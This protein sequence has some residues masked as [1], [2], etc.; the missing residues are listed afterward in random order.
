MKRKK[1]GQNAPPLGHGG[2]K[3]DSNS[4]QPT[5]QIKDGVRNMYNLH[6]EIGWFSYTNFCPNYFKVGGKNPTTSLPGCNQITR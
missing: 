1:V 6:C 3:R 2:V 4:M 5:I